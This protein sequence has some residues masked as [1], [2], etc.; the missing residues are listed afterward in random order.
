MKKKKK[1]KSR[2]NPLGAV[3]RKATER[4]L[5]RM[6]DEHDRPQHSFRKGEIN[7]WTGDALASYVAPS[8]LRSVATWLRSRR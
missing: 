1:K 4:A 5:K 8:V 6:E 3:I 2:E 7:G